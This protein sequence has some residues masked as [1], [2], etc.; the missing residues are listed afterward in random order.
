MNVSFTLEE[1]VLILRLDDPILRT[2]ADCDDTCFHLTPST[3]ASFSILLMCEGMFGLESWCVLA[4]SRKEAVRLKVRYDLGQREQGE[5][6]YA[7]SGPKSF[8]V[9]NG[10]FDAFKRLYKLPVEAQD[11]NLAQLDRMLNKSR[12]LALLSPIEKLPQELMSSIYLHLRPAEYI[13]LG[14]CSHSLWIRVVATI[15]HNRRSSSWANTPIFLTATSQLFALRQTVCNAKSEFRTLGKENHDRVGV[16]IRLENPQ[17]FDVLKRAWNQNLVRDS[18]S[19][20]FSDLEPPYCQQLTRLLPSSKIPESLHVLMKSCLAPLERDVQ[21][22]WCLRDLTTNEYIRME[23]VQ[24]HATSNHT[25]VSLAGS[26]WMTLDILLVWLISWQGGNDK[27]SKQVPGGNP[28]NQIKKIFTHG[29]SVGEHEIAQVRSYFTDMYFGRWA[30]HSL[31]VVK[32][33]RGKIGDGWTDVT[34]D[35]EDVSQRW[36]AAMYL[37]AHLMGNEDMHIE[38]WNQFAQ[39]QMNKW[40]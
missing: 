37:E 5:F 26:P 4:P 19:L 9:M 10:S 3:F 14:L 2:N 16:T 20:T 30:G 28:K 33:A 39:D 15:H 25:I 27:T 31:D 11:L 32:L 35:I 40:A 34:D 12:G 36:F 7:I 17:L 13:S 8:C 1:T 21:G 24:N 6:G 18:A 23:L 29:D 38:Y 22:L